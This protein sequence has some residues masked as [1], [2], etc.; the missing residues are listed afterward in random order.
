MNDISKIK[1]LAGIVSLN[2]PN[3]PQAIITLV[4]SIGAYK[5]KKQ[6]SGSINNLLIS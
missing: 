2:G 4:N 1:L 3:K 5:V 6:I